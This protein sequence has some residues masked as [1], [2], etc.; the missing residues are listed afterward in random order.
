M[1]GLCYLVALS[2]HTR[3]CARRGDMP[4]TVAWA[5]INVN[6]INMPPG[7]TV[8]GMYNEEWHLGRT[9]SRR[10][11]RQW[12]TEQKSFPVEDGQMQ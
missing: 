3:Y 10:K 9:D 5:T 4:W 2:M 11:T 7:R 8:S 12:S 1:G 6:G